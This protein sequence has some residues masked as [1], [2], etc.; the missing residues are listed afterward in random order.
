[1]ETVTCNYCGSDNYTTIYRVPDL[2]L[3]N[4]SELFSMVRCDRCGLIYQNPRPTQE[5]LAK[6]YPDEYEPY[7]QELSENRITKKVNRYGIEKRCRLVNTLPNRSKGGRLLDVGCSTGIFLDFIRQSGSWE[8]KGI[9]VSEYA[10]TVAREKYQLDVFTGTLDEA[11]FPSAFFDVVTLWDVLEH[12]P[13]PMGTLAE[14][15][16]ITKSDGYLMIRIPHLDSLDAKLFGP[17]WAG[18]DLPRHYYV[19]SKQKINLFLSKNGYKIHKISGGIGNYPTFVLSIRF[20]LTNHAVGLGKRNKIISF[21]NHPLSKIAT[22]PFFYLY[23]SFLL[24]SEIIVIAKK[25]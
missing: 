6:Y 13:D 3:D 5:E 9:E 21:L 18:L 4:N 8:V 10:A 15:S 14:I 23:G 22:A 1:M 25:V 20:W 17:S 19:F 7:Y 11:R 16:R 12:L 2:L 24:G